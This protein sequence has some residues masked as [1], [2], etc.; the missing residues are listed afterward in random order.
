M[1]RRLFTVI[2][3][4]ALINPAGLFALSRPEKEFKIFQFP[5]NMMPRID[6]K[7]GDWDF[8]PAEYTY[9]TY[10]LND[11]EDGN[12]RNYDLKD[13][14]VQ[15]TVGW[16]NGMSRLYFLYEVYDDFFDC[17]RSDLHN[18]IFEIAVDADLS[19]GPFI[20]NEQI[21]D[22]GIP[23][24]VSRAYTRRTTISLRPR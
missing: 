12:G 24:F 23:I 13:L 22:R 9:D 2:L 16:V 4:L 14:D 5:H 11:T 6:G 7:T 15:V 20:S 8:I 21:S 1:M 19:G 10:E 17:A 18:D 3:L